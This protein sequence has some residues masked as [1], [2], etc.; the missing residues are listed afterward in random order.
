MLLVAA[1]SR[2]LLAL[3]ATCPA[4][5][6]ELDAKVQQW[7]QL[8]TEVISS[9]SFDHDV[10]DAASDL[11]E[12]AR[13]ILALFM[14]VLGEELAVSTE[15]PDPVARRAA[16]AEREDVGEENGDGSDIDMRDV[17]LRSRS[18]AA[19]FGVVDPDEWGSVLRA[20]RQAINDAVL[21]RIQ[22]MLQ[23]AYV[24]RPA[25]AVQPHE[26]GEY[27][28]IAFAENMPD[29]AVM[30][31]HHQNRTRQ[32]TRRRRLREEF[33]ADKDT[34]IAHRLEQDELD[35]QARADLPEPRADDGAI[36]ELQKALQRSMFEQYERKAKERDAKI[37]ELQQQVDAAAGSQ[38]GNTS[39][40]EMPYGTATPA[41]TKVS[42]PEGYVVP[43]SVDTAASLGVGTT[44]GAFTSTPPSVR[45]TNYNTP[46]PVRPALGSQ[47][48]RFGGTS[49]PPTFDMPVRTTPASGAYANSIQPNTKALGFAQS[50]PFKS[51]DAKPLKD[52]I[53]HR[54][55]GFA[56]LLS[57]PEFLA[58]RG[59]LVDLQDDPN[60]DP[61]AN[62]GS[63]PAYSASITSSKSQLYTSEQ[64]RDM[65]APTM[66]DDST[67]NTQDLFGSRENTPTPRQRMPSTETTPVYEK[68]NSWFVTKPVLGVRSASPTS[69]ES[70]PRK[71]HSPTVHTPPGSSFGGPR[72]PTA[73]DPSHSTSQEESLDYTKGIAVSKHATRGLGVDLGPNTAASTGRAQT[74]NLPRLRSS[75]SPNTNAWPLSRT[76][77]ST[78]NESS[79]WDR[80]ST[81][82]PP[83]IQEEDS[84]D[85]ESSVTEP[86]PRRV[87]VS[88]AKQS[89]AS[90]NSSVPSDPRQGRLNQ[91]KGLM[92]RK[93]SAILGRVSPEA[94]RSH[95]KDSGST[96]SSS[97]VVPRTSGSIS[98]TKSTRQSVHGGTH[99]DQD[100]PKTNSM[101][102]GAL[103]SARS[104]VSDRPT[105][106]TADMNRSPS[107]ESRFQAIIQRVGMQPDVLH[108]F[109][110]NN[111]VRLLYTELQQAVHDGNLDDFQDIL[112]A[113]S[114]IL[115]RNIAGSFRL[116]E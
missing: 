42:R 99:G 90:D 80:N 58:S 55:T 64:R 53:G 31:M 116:E 49:Q 100:G 13:A 33:L 60:F 52:T 37:K 115:T 95:A 18:G 3:L 6:K 67:L 103:D 76:K 27:L 98:P 75:R 57:T 74:T 93:K 26:I 14:M 29:W 12:G 86:L 96:G 19:L 101:E 2:S 1:D 8:V 41:P 92:S 65:R 66:S 84:I 20:V 35:K 50:E 36:S 83:T 28:A 45:P 17:D 59:R 9:G 82:R 102:T 108:F 22:Q 61:R 16:E 87:N 15:P 69:E 79:L 34:H 40:H 106:N 24:R 47:K 48:A 5:Q 88:P 89:E 78:T 32:A 112:A 56:P 51:T 111:S 104:A 94:S 85:Q 11:V 107:L 4:R 68:R 77:Y 70:T 43:D 91:L 81:R 109:L 110:S 105:R 30:V 39:G 113:L 73:S 7:H 72:S 21:P 10:A 44:P 114:A 63:P 38:Q 46:T 25:D 62:L 71:R 54:G 97:T 23:D